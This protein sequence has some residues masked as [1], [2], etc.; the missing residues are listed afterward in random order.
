[1]SKTAE[2]EELLKSG[3]EPG[4]IISLGYKK[5]TV[6]KV[7]KTLLGDR[8]PKGGEIDIGKLPE[9]T[10]PVER[11]IR[12]LKERVSEIEGKLSESL[13]IEIRQKFNCDCGAERFV[14]MKVMCTKCGREAWWGWWP[15]D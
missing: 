11:E 2:I 10:E 8:A 6:Y 4:E 14:A 5:P 13:A 15:K 3:K 7:R 1:M 12:R 9:R